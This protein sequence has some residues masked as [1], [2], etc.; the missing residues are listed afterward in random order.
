MRPAAVL[1]ALLVALAGC[2]GQAGEPTPTATSFDTTSKERTGVGSVTS[3]RPAAPLVD[4][5]GGDL[6]V[7]A[8]A[9]YRRTLGL[10]GV[11]PGDGTTVT[12][13][14]WRGSA[15]PPP[16]GPPTG[17][18]TPFGRA[19]GLEPSGY[20]GDPTV[21]GK[22]DAYGVTVRFREDARPEPVGV[23]LAHEFA[24]VLQYRLDENDAL[25]ER[26]GTETYLGSTL[27]EGEAEH[28]QQRVATERF[29]GHGTRNVSRVYHEADGSMKLNVAPYYFGSQYFADHPELV[30]AYDR[31]PTTT[32]QVLHGL[33]PGA[34]P[35][36]PLDV[37]TTVRNESLRVGGETTRGELFLRVV[38]GDELNRSAATAGADGWGNDRLV[39]LDRTDGRT[40]GF[41]WIIR[42]DDAGEAAEFRRVAAAY[43]DGRGDRT[44]NGW[45]ADGMR[46]E[47]RR[48]S[49]GTTAF[50]AVTDGFP[51]VTTA[52][53]GGNVSVTVN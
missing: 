43:L 35:A 37:S 48:V 7:D 38:L 33:E 5:R 19:F 22:A 13:G 44:T 8:V 51:S 52:G 3:A 21:T 15:A 2:G 24:H 50:L 12:I 26:D 49:P 45:R 10:Y 20:P 39:R 46:F 27:R 47:L 16:T 41:V 14:E 1:L 42:W 30:G 29:G 31:Q 17:P 32:E 11:E 25:A 40:E 9:V 18:T 23:V 53:A 28:V 6:P 34:E 4:V 36:R